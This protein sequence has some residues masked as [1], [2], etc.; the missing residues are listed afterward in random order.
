MFPPLCSRTRWFWGR[1]LHG[2]QNFLSWC[3][4]WVFL[5]LC[6]VIGWGDGCRQV[7]LCVSITLGNLLGSEIPELRAESSSQCSLLLSPCPSSVLEFCTHPS[8]LLA[9]GTIHCFLCFGFPSLGHVEMLP[10]TALSP[11]L[12]TAVFLSFVSFLFYFIFFYPFPKQATTGSFRHSPAN[13]LFSHSHCPIPTFCSCLL[14][15]AVL[16]GL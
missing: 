8:P 10:H 11:S 15:L 2:G 13:Y 4:F 6:P 9:P 16:S 3:E 14:V 7:R 1:C 5:E 12:F